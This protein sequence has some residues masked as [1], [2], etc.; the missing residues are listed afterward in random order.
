MKKGDNHLSSRKRLIKENA[1]SYLIQMIYVEAYAYLRKK[2]GSMNILEKNLKDMGERIGISIYKYYN[3]PH[4]SITGTIKILLRNI[5]GKEVEVIK[6]HSE[7][8]KE[9]IGFSVIFKKC[10]LC[11]RTGLEEEGVAY[12]LPVMSIIEK[13][14]NL[15]LN[16][17]LIKKEFEMLEGKVV[18][19]VSGGDDV[20][21]YYYEII[22]E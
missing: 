14:L 13:Y 15:A 11:T 16:N 21:E 6:N 4:N 3:P 20:C 18:K 9:I 12:C 7:E 1:S 5:V 2:Y 10:P 8:D 17:G 22:R 19:S